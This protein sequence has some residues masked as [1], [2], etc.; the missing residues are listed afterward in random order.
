MHTTRRQHLGLWA[1]LLGAPAATALAQGTPTANPAS[2]PAELF[3]QRPLFSG[4]KLSPDGRNVAV[5][6]RSKTQRARLGVVDLQTM[7]VVPVAAF[8]GADVG[9]FEW[10][11]DQRLVYTAT[12]EG[13]AEADLEFAPGLFAVNADGTG[14]RQLVERQR[15]FAASGTAGRELPWNTF[16]LQPVGLPGSPDVYVVQP[17]AYSDK[18]ADFFNLL[19]LNTVS[20]RSEEL[21]TPNNCFAWLFDAGGQLRMVVT[22][23]DDTAALRVAEPGGAGGKTNWRRVREFDRFLGGDLRPRWMS[24]DGRVYASARVNRDTTAVYTYDPA[25]DRLSETPVLATDGYDLDPHFIANDKG[26]LGLR[27]VTDAVTTH[28]VDDDMKALQADID[29]QLATT[30]NL[31]TPPRRG[32]SPFVLVQAF[33]DVQPDVYVLYDRRNKKLARLGSELPDVRASTC[34]LYT[35]PSPR[36]H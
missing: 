7:A 2:L 32:D 22:E 1:A 34:L 20:G 33:S 11:N 27:V 14:Y 19:R 6:V 4:A 30:S 10:V 21:D 23:K 29:K 36:D 16:F 31:L 28:W 12:D 35:S 3:F 5:R 24:P 17:Q 26:L 25:T 9:H 8:T 18:G 13:I 15:V